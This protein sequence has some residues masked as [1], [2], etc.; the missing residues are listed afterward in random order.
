MINFFELMIAIRFLRSKRKD[1]FISV[2]SFFS[3][4]G[5]AL[6]VAT[7]II[8]MSVMNGYHSEFVKNI[9]GIQ[10]HITA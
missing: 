9:L 8:V 3:F 5:I 10:G 7:L 2:V 6:G 1:G 4:I